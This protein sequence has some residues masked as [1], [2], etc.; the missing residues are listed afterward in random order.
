MERLFMKDHLELIED[1]KEQ[2]WS[3][4]Q[5]KAYEFKMLGYEHVTA[6]EIWECVTSKYKKGVPRLHQVV[7]DI[8]S[9]KVT[10]FMNWM[11]MKIYQGGID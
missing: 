9:L 6:E 2:L 8:L 3:L 1:L 4:C 5:S 10:K 11:T 7:N